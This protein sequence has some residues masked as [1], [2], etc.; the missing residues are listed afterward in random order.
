MGLHFE[1]FASDTAVVSDGRT[2]TEADLV[3]FAALTG[4]ATA[5]HLDEEYAKATRF[6]R[7]IAHGALIFGMSIGLATQTGILDETV[8]A[9]AGVDKLRFVTPVFIGDTIHVE[10]RVLERKDLGSS[11]GAVT[12]ESR[13]VNQRGELVLVYLD[14]LLIKRRMQVR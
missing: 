7:R 4:D 1:D 2:V 10:K 8:I 3:A 14:K 11:Q 12:F 9:F 5:L 6:G 13:V